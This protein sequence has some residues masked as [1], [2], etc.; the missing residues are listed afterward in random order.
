MTNPSLQELFNHVEPADIFLSRLT[1]EDIMF[2]VDDPAINTLLLIL[3][4]YIA[5]VRGFKNNILITYFARTY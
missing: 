1:V 5:S 2:D 3:K 4:Y